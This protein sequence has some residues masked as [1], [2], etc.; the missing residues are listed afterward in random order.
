M[1][2]IGDIISQLEYILNNDCSDEAEID[3]VATRALVNR[4]TYMRILYEQGVHERTQ[5]MFHVLYVYTS[6]GQFGIDM[7][8]NVPAN[9]ISYRG[10]TVDDIN[11]EKILLGDEDIEE[12]I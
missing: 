7:D 4:S 2:F 3:L 1:N 5:N 11:V 8:L 12:F 10:R 9:K 6:R